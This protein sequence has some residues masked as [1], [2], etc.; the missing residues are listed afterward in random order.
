MYKMVKPNT[1]FIAMM[2]IVLSVVVAVAA[3]QFII[4]QEAKA[5]TR[6]ELQCA[7][8]NIK[9]DEKARCEGHVP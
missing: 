3:S 9:S 8:A 6:P 5:I 2:A 7:K 4:I 1:F